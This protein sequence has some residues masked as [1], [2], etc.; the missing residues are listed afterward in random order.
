VTI[1]GSQSDLLI[2]DGP[3]WAKIMD[4]VNWL[5]QTTVLTLPCTGSTGCA[6]LAA[7]LPRKGVL[8]ALLQSHKY[9]IDQWNKI[10]LAGFSAGHGL[11]EI[12]LEDPESNARIAALG[13][14]DSYYTGMTAGIKPGYDALAARA[15]NEEAIMWTSSSSFPGPGYISCE[16]AIKPL[17]DKYGPTP[18]DLPGDLGSRL[19][20]PLYCVQRG[21]WVHAHFGDHYKHAEHATVIGPAVFDAWIAPAMYTAMSQSTLVTIGKVLGAAALAGLSFIGARALIA[22]LR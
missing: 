5:H 14:F 6:A 13:A 1:Q 19:K 7:N 16:D 8:A 12:L 4:P 10:M 2:W 22:R 21:S 18:A 9:T 3:I 20:P 17:L 15:V 11:N